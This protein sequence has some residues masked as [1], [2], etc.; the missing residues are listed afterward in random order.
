MTQE[1]DHFEKLQ[2]RADLYQRVFK[3]PDGK[4]VL[5]D[6]KQAWGVNQTVF[7][8]VLKDGQAQQLDPY[9]TMV[10]AARRDCYDM[11]ARLCGLTYEDIVAMKF[12]SESG[13]DDA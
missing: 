9:Y 8:F 11:I 3:T 2:R 6:L 13:E 5:D 10:L 7:S 12:Y 4:A 1:E